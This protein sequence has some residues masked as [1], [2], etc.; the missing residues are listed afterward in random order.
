ML[1]VDKGLGLWLFD[2]YIYTKVDYQEIDTAVIMSS[3]IK[4]DK[5]YLS[6]YRKG[7]CIID[8]QTDEI[9]S[10]DTTNSG[11]SFDVI[12]TMMVTED[13]IWMCTD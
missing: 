4:D 5:L 10:Y 7:L 8:L 13:E 9:K 1:L 2:G 12:L 11:L 6:L 3:A